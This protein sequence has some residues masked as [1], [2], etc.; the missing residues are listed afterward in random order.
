MNLIIIQE[1]LAG[2]SIL[3]LGTT[4][5]MM[6]QRL[7]EHTVVSGLMILNLYWVY[8]AYA[9]VRL[10]SEKGIGLVF[11]VHFIS[12]ISALILWYLLNG[13]IPGQEHLMIK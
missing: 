2:L 11:Y 12:F 10:N 3:C 6:V 9:Q 1:L 13:V 5:L 7:R 8:K 4:Y